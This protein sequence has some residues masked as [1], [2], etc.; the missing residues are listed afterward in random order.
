MDLD[1]FCFVLVCAFDAYHI[2]I[3]RPLLHLLVEHRTTL[4]VVAS[5]ESAVLQ[6]TVISWEVQCN[7]NRSCKWQ[8]C[9]ANRSYGTFEAAAGLLQ[10]DPN[11]QMDTN[12]LPTDAFEGYVVES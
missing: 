11:R 5:E 1:I 12:A 6:T 2:E 4:T 9:S 8:S 7:A 10:M 3:D